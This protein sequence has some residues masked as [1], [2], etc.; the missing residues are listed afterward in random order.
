MSNSVRARVQFRDDTAT[1]RMIIRHAME[2]GGKRADGRYVAAHFITELMC[3]HNSE[4]VLRAYWGPGIAK[5]PYLSFTIRPAKSGD[6]L[7]VRWVD[8]Q[9]MSDE[10][11]MRI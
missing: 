7:H 11:T 10:F 1:V 5:D 2:V 9:G 4:P 8:N 6:E 3:H